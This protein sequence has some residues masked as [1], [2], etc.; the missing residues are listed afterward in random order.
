MRAPSKPLWP[1]SRARASA[2]RTSHAKSHVCAHCPGH[3][4]GLQQEHRHDLVRTHGAAHRHAVLVL[5]Q[6]TVWV[7][8]SGASGF[9]LRAWRRAL[10]TSLRLG[11]H[12]FTSAVLRSMSLTA[13][14]MRS[15]RLPGLAYSWS[16][17]ALWYSTS[18]ML[19]AEGKALAGLT[20]FMPAT[21]SWLQRRQP[22]SQP[23][24]VLENR[25]NSLLNLAGTVK[26]P[27]TRRVGVRTCG[28]AWPA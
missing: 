9:S 24:S 12:A 18:S 11:S 26:G 1:C 2:L 4:A 28:A 8:P 16:E 5:V 25:C 22:C 13:R 10:S 14:P 7:S 6:W 27:G 20:L 3:I 17:E 19:A 21:F 23:A 15:A